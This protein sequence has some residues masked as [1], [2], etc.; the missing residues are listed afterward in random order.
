M[1]A[2]AGNVSLPVRGSPCERAE[3]KLNGSKA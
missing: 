1:V 3:G 2:P